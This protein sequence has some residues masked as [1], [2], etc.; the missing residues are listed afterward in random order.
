MSTSTIDR[1][2]EE[3]KTHLQAAQKLADEADRDNAGDFTDEQRAQ[4]N[5]HGAKAREKLAHLKQAQA[6]D[7]IRAAIRDLG[8]GISLVDGAAE[9]KSRREQVTDSGL[10]VPDGRKSVSQHFIES[11]AY[12][13]LLA[14]APNGQ[15]G[16]KM[17]VQSA[18]V[19]FKAL[20][21][22]TSDT[23]AGALVE[24]DRLGT[25]V[26]MDSF[27]RPLTLRDLVTNGTTGTDQVE[28]R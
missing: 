16:E 24:S 1:L 25:F 27:Q 14:S 18:P 28:P 17:R 6:D 19:G 9:A 21:T 8:D 4:V 7:Q 15:F 12:K 10:I 20:I 11:A 5:E 2:T 13:G 3:L 23:S 26:G 22:G